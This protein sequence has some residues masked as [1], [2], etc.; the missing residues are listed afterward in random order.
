MVSF[1]DFK[2]LLKQDMFKKYLIIAERTT[3][4]EQLVKMMMEVKNPDFGFFNGMLKIS[5]AER[6]QIIT[7]CKNNPIFNK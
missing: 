1:D 3:S 2:M 6:S 7:K 4:I 5:E